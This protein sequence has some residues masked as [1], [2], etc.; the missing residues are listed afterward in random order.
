MDK[1]IIIES[2]RVYD[3]A[4]KSGAVDK[5]HVILVDN[6]WTRIVKPPPSDSL[7]AVILYD[8]D[9]ADS[10]DGIISEESIVR[11]LQ[12][13]LVLIWC[14]GPGWC[15]HLQCPSLHKVR[16][17]GNPEECGARGKKFTFFRHVCGISVIVSIDNSW[18]FFLLKNTGKCASRYDWE[19]QRRHSIHGRRRRTIHKKSRR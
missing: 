9:I 2:P 13:L 10:T 17:G 16:F 19:R 11:I 3:K 5:D 6:H 8:P 1:K 12:L 14:C 18:F 4:I 15:C 7:T